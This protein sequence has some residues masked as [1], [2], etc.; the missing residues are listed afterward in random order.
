MAQPFVG[1]RSAVCGC[2]YLLSTR[3]DS[4]ET[5]KVSVSLTNDKR[6]LPPEHF[7]SSFAFAAID[8]L[9]IEIDSL[10]GSTFA[11]EVDDLAA[12]SFRESMPQFGFE[13][14]I[15]FKCY[16]HVIDFDR[17]IFNPNLQLSKSALASAH[18]DPVAI[19]FEIH[20]LLT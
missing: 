3:I 1:R 5:P 9:V 7:N 12:G 13:G 10:D 17:G 19:I 18:V 14:L 15:I 20:L 16:D 6:V 4:R 2:F 8:T 11:G